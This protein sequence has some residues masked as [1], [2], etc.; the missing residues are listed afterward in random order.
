SRRCQKPP[1][2]TQNT[3]PLGSVPTKLI[4]PRCGIYV[5]MARRAEDNT[6]PAVVVANPDEEVTPESFLAWLET[7]QKGPPRHIFDRP[8][9]P[10]GLEA[11]LQL[12]AIRSAGQAAVDSGQLV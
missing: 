2:W 9:D 7:R 10:S 6:D 1:W 5:D 11:A 8:S 4:W 3:M 12:P